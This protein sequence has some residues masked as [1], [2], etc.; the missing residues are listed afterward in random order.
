MRISAGIAKGRRTATRGL[1]TRSPGARKVRPTSAKVREALFDI[2]RGKIE[3]ATFVDLYAGT[4]TVGFEALSRGASHALFVEPDRRLIAGMKKCAL[5]LGFSDRALIMPQRAEE[6]L[7]RA[8]VAGQSYDIFFLDPPYHSREIERI[9]P[10]LASGALVPDGGIVVVEHFFKKQMPGD[11]GGLVLR[12]RYRYGD[13]MLTFYGK[14]EREREDDEKSD[15]S[16][17]V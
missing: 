5:D 10:V 9:L 3:G 6:F 15:L 1:L 13:T 14:A 12:K 11:V 7:S 4:G 2:L 17:N 8:A 16:G